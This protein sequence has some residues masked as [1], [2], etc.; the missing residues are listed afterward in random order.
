LRFPVSSIPLPAILRYAEQY[1][2]RTIEYCDVDDLKPEHAAEIKLILQRAAKAHSGQAP[3][4]RDASRHGH[5]HG[6]GSREASGT[7]TA[8][9][10]DAATATT[11]A[12]AS[13][14]TVPG[15]GTS[16]A[17]EV[18]VEVLAD[19]SEHSASQ[20]RAFELQEECGSW[21]LLARQAVVDVMFLDSN[22]LEC[23]AKLHMS[24][25]TTS[26]SIGEC[27]GCCSCTI[28]TP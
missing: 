23:Q 28:R 27:G 4:S 25:S 1:A 2:E 18:P 7:P 26:V 10:L 22:Q 21:F 6:H 19:G 11:T 17:G 24:T 16:A 15:V 3:S 12:G 14:S 13:S 20:F 9:L 8:E 5:G